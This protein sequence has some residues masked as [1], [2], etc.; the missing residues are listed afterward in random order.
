[1]RITSINQ[2]N[3]SKLKHHR[4][5]ALFLILPISI[6]M[7][8]TTVVSSQVQ[9]FQN[10]ANQ[11]IFGTIETQATLINLQKVPQAPGGGNQRTF[12]DGSNEFTSSDIDK[13]SQINNVKSASINSQVPIENINTKDLF[14][15]TNYKLSNIVEIDPTSASLYSPDNFSYTEGQ[16]I[17]IILNASSFTQQYED[18]GDKTEVDVTFNRGTRGGRRNGGDAATQPQNPGQA[19]ADAGAPI[20][21]Q[22]IS[23][24]KN[25]LIGKTF[26]VQIGGLDEITD[27]KIEPSSGTIKFIKLTQAEIDAK[28]ETEKTD[29]SKYWDYN[30]ISTPQTFT[31]KVAGI[32]ESD[33]N[34]KTYIPAEAADAIMNKY[35]KNQLDAR[36]STVVPTDVLNSTYRGM[37][38]DGTTLSSGRGQFGGFG[39]GRGGIRIQGPNGNAGNATESYNIPGLVVE[40]KNDGSQDVVGIYNDADVYKN[41]AKNG[42]SISIKIN[43][44]YDRDQVVKDL[45][46]AGFAY[47]DL[48]NLGVFN[49]LRNTLN[50][51]STGFTIAFIVLSIGVIIFAMSKFVSESRKEIGIFRAI[52]MKKLDIVKL[53]A[54]QAIVYVLIG[55]LIGAALGILLN[56]V[57]AGFMKSWFDSLIVNTV[58]QTFNVVT[59]VD[60][61]IFS[62]VALRTI[63]YYSIALVIITLLISLIPALKASSVSPVEAI[64]GE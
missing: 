10:A 19:L 11:S 34:N 26:T 46:S 50:S 43:S 38:Y 4:V 13:I 54:L 48:N 39:G 59:T 15:N 32:I 16:P 49:N 61:S 58:K 14:S 51:I 41:S 52:G 37:T 18:W 36:N 8:L 25:S 53:F 44:V 5:K 9:N 60:G 30:K 31:F 62:H 42:Q 12:I 56:F 64:K 47:Q 55:Y 57:T 27:Y 28:K 24:D 17:P 7:I 20:K 29:A 21:T 63:G 35:I 1:M 3:L 22:K 2:I 6:L 45:N 33:S 40:L 23:Y